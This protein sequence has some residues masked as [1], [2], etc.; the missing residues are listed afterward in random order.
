MAVTAITVGHATIDAAIRQASPSQIA[1]DTPWL[2]QALKGDA[3]QLATF[4]SAAGVPVDLNLPM[5][6]GSYPLHAV[7]RLGHF[8]V[9][10]LLVENGANPGV[11]DYAGLTAFD[12]ALFTKEE[13]AVAA[14]ISPDQATIVN[15]AL[16]KPVPPVREKQVLQAKTALQ[17]VVTT[18][19][20]SP[21][22]LDLDGLHNILIACDNK[23]LATLIDLDEG[24]NKLDFSKNNRTK[25]GLTPLHCALL[26]QR[27]D[28]VD[29]I[30]NRFSAEDFIAKDARGMTPVHY[31]AMLGFS[32]LVEKMLTA[33]GTLDKK[34]P[35]GTGVF[36]SRFT[37]AEFINREHTRFGY[38]LA[39]LAIAANQPTVL[40]ALCK[41]G[42]NLSQSIDDSVTAAELLCS[43]IDAKDPLRVTKSQYLLAA[44]NILTLATEFTIP[45]LVIPLTFLGIAANGFFAEKG[46]F[47][48]QLL[49]WSAEALSMAVMSGMAL[50]PGVKVAVDLWRVKSVASGAFNALYHAYKGAR[51]ETLKAVKKATVHSAIAASTIYRSR[52][53]IQY[54]LNCIA[55]VPEIV[56]DLATYPERMEDLKA[57]TAS[58]LER[59]DRVK[60]DQSELEQRE[61][62]LEQKEVDLNAREGMSSSRHSSDKGAHQSPNGPAGRPQTPKA[63]NQFEKS[64]SDKGLYSTLKGYFSWSS[65][66]SPDEA[67]IPSDA[68]DLG[69][70][71][72]GQEG[73]HITLGSTFIPGTKRGNERDK[74]SLLTAE[75][76]GQYAKRWGLNH[77]VIVDRDILKG[78]CTI[79]NNPTKVECSPYWRKISILKDWL[80]G[81]NTT[82]PK[83]KEEWYM[84]IDDDMV[85][86]NQ[87]IDPFDALDALRGGTNGDD[88]S[89]IVAEDVGPWAGDPV[90]SVNTGALFVRRDAR[91][92][93]IIQEIWD[94]RNQASGVEV[95]EDY[96]I[97]PTLGFCGQQ[98]SL[99]EQAALGDII[100]D[101]FN[102]NGIERHRSTSEAKYHILAQNGISVVKYRDQ[103]SKTRGH[104]ALN[105]FE[106]SGEFIRHD[107]GWTSD[108]AWSYSDGGSPQ[109][110]WRIGDWMGQTAGVPVW[111]WY[112][113]DKTAGKL[114]GPL[115]YDKLKIMIDKTVH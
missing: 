27:E 63:P 11:K 39:K 67:L 61:I 113:A 107:K 100:Q 80:G 48:G 58:V 97:C 103:V 95:P 84:M 54:A 31:A 60:K 82:P 1:S 46:G 87:K 43:E 6:D 76:H 77:Q 59:E 111:G 89:F 51:Y 13:E 33:I 49:F 45:Q 105:T 69:H 98:K 4:F 55:S 94:K 93:E 62:E 52:E 23:N 41:M 71:Y 104:I 65:S 57:K 50:I 28:L 18:V 112:S 86:S 21:R 79:E 15:R 2:K 64:K 25:H 108:H 32:G 53:S 110:A 81:S 35:G 29:V 8:D 73:R 91:A 115:R 96:E 101:I 85:I 3:A 5:S 109:G 24:I 70:D 17:S 78:Q 26:S 34:T 9:A 66:S 99:H 44:Y 114:P 102:L 75:N 38:S 12:H 83:G 90:K 92:L 10:K 88:T 106:R 20:S 30:F 40:S 36:N 14:L 22:V 16:N 56:H 68:K 37:I 42:A 74:L 72:S 19:L 47:K 7:I